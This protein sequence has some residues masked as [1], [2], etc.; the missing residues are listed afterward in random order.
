MDLEAN[1]Y[2]DSDG[3]K[4]ARGYLDFLKDPKFLMYLCFLI[5]M[6][7]ILGSLSLDFQHDSI[8]ACEINRRVEDKMVSIDGLVITKG[9]E[10]RKLLKDMA[11]VDGETTQGGDIKFKDVVLDRPTGI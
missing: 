11:V 4:K 5:D 2:G 3:A 10:M 1:S 6:V 8:L 9:P 7:S